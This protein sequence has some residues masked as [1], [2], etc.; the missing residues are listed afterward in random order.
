MARARQDGKN[1]FVDLTA[2]EAQAF[3]DAVSGVVAEYV[4]SVGGD[5]ALA[6]M[7]N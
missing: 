5:A 3:T 1:T 4:A 2:E 7:Q 6:A